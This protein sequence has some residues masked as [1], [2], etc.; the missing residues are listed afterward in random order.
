MGKRAH[1]GC[2][3]RSLQERKR[4]VVAVLLENTL[5]DAVLGVVEHLMRGTAILAHTRD[6]ELPLS[7]VDPDT[8]TAVWFIRLRNMTDNPSLGSLVGHGHMECDLLID[9]CGIPTRR[10]A[11]LLHET[12]LV[13]EGFD[14][15]PA[16]VS[17]N[18]DETLSGVGYA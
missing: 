15:H 17:V 9:P 5:D 7:N 13:L 10:G 16:Q 3:S 1:T 6:V 11:R 4:T 14:A 2:A 18:F 8:Q 12:R